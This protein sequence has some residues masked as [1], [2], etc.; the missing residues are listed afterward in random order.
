VTPHEWGVAGSR[1]TIVTIVATLA[2][3]LYLWRQRRQWRKR[4]Y[5]ERKYVDS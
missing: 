2:R 1:V 3:A 5:R 4:M